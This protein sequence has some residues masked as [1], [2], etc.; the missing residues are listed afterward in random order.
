MSAHLAQI[1]VPRLLAPID[2]PG[3]AD[4]VAARALIAPIRRR[5][6]PGV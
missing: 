2:A 5:E 1:N 3:T 4:F 6:L